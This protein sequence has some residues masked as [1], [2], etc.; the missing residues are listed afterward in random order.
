[1][2]NKDIEKALADARNARAQMFLADLAASKMRL[3]VWNIENPDH[4]IFHI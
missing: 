2:K 1:M 3:I 4:I